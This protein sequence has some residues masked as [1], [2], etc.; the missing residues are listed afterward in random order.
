MNAIA[1]TQEA[2]LATHAA[3]FPPNPPPLILPV[4][5]PETYRQQYAAHIYR[6][7]ES[8]RWAL[9]QHR[10]E[11]IAA[12]ALVALCGRHLVHTERFP[13]AIIAIG[14]RMATE[15]KRL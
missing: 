5:D 1:A 3:Q 12:G 7:A 13:D 8:F 2:P 14:Q 15:L 9:R 6:T 10:E 4:M 11:L